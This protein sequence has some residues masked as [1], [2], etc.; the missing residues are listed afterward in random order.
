MGLGLAF[1]LMRV[2]N[3]QFAPM[4]VPVLREQAEPGLLTARAHNGCST[5]ALAETRSSRCMTHM[6]EINAT[7]TSPNNEIF[8]LSTDCPPHKATD[9]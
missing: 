3:S 8:L 6:K 1:A 9:R 2:P 4:C 7:L 5:V